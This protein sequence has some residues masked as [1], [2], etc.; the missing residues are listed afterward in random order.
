MKYPPMC[1]GL[2]MDRLNR[3]AARVEV[4]GAPCTV[5][6]RNSGRLAELLRPAARVLLIRA[7][8]PH[9]KTRFDLAL[10]RHEG[11]WVSVNAHIA[12]DLFHEAIEGGSLEAFA[13]TTLEK[14]EI[15]VGNSRLDFLLSHSDGKIYVEVKSV[16]LVVDGQARFPDAPTTRGTKHLHELISLAKK[17]GVRAAAVFVVQRNDARSFTPNAIMDPEFAQALR[18][19]K[20]SDVS[21][22][23][24]ACEVGPKM[25][26]IFRPVDII[27]DG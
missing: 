26:R 15:T 19:A 9:R 2:F 8:A 14:R 4:D 21:I 5:A 20:K 25:I 12:N 11:R 13:G 17:R 27:L 22:F 23:A 1:Q 24:Y 6:V 3:F 16:T 10:V 18:L 7:N